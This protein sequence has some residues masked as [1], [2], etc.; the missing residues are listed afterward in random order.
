MRTFDLIIVGGGLG[1]CSLGAYLARHGADVLILERESVYRDRVRGEGI[2][3]WG[4]VEAKRL[5]I[6]DQLLATCAREVPFWGRTVVDGPS[7][8]RDLR[9]T[10]P[11][12]LGCLNFLH[13]EMQQELAQ[14]AVDAGAT[15][16]MGA[17]VFDVAPGVSPCARYRWNGE[18][19]TASGRLLI[20]ADGRASKVR[21]WAGFEVKRDPDFLIVAST[22][23]TSMGAP[24]DTVSTF[25][26]PKIGR[27]SL[28]YPVGEGRCRTYLV[29]RAADLTKRFSGA[30]DAAHF[31]TACVEA[32]VPAEYYSR[33]IQAGP[34]ASFSGASAWVAHPARNG[35]ALIG[36]AAGASDPSFGSGLSLTLRDVR[37]LADELLATEDWADAADAYARKHDESFEALHT[38][39]HW[40]ERIGYG[41]GP[42]NDELRRRAT[43]LLASDPSRRPDIHGLGPDAPH[44]ELARRRFFGQG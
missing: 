23:H 31:V 1:G 44:D 43:P 33:S 38:I 42:E 2:F 35:V 39:L 7:A 11:S 3:P 41:V 26:N 8:K 14:M 6:Y 19:H 4:C 5:G 16:R 34:L 18:E 15:L 12:G 32:G 22:L 37:L 27:T 29:Y 13:H 21:G 20:G 24:Q 25:S 17:E 9:A 40:W 30:R 28:V 36:D 10:T